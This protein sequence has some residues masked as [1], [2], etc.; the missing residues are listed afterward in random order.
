MKV[1]DGLGVLDVNAVGVGVFVSVGRL[2]A[3]LVILSVG[4]WVILGDGV[5][6]HMELGVLV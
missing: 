5:M 3:E 4:V 1:G 6:V 2:V